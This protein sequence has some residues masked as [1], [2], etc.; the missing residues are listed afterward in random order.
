MAIQTFYT[1]TEQCQS[2]YI[3]FREKKIQLIQLQIILAQG[4]EEKL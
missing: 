2:M 3:Y 4:P 1:A